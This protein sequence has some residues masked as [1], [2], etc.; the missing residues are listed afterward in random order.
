MSREQASVLQAHGL[1]EQV[2]ASVWQT[3]VPAV[4]PLTSLRPTQRPGY[5][6]CGPCRK[7]L[8]EPSRSGDPWP[9]VLIVNGVAWI[10]DGHNRIAKWL[11]EGRAY[12]PAKVA[13]W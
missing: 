1:P 5:R 2:P 4:V 10:Y 12:G 11:R 6:P 8:G 3:L 7:L 9:Y 13:R